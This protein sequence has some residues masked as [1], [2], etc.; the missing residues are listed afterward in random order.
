MTRNRET[1]WIDPPGDCSPLELS[2]TLELQGTI[3][4][5]ELRRRFTSSGPGVKIREV[6]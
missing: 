4:T 3:P 5:A 1:E 6:F 2:S